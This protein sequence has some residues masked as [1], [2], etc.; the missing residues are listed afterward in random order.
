MNKL[1]NKEKQEWIIANCCGDYFGEV[2][3]K[4]LDFGDRILILSN[5]KAR[6]I[7]NNEQEAEII[8]NRCQKANTIFNNDQEAD[9]IVNTE[10]DEWQNI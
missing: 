7:K 3:L 4:G 5:I 9:E 1:T 10:Q 2:S 6:K 8:N